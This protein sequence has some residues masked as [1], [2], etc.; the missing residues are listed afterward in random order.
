[1]IFFN[2]IERVIILILFY[3]PIIV[4]TSILLKKFENIF[5]NI[6]KKFFISIDV[7][8]LNMFIIIKIDKKFIHDR[9]FFKFLNILSKF[10][11]DIVVNNIKLIFDENYIN[12]FD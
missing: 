9:D 1:M 12:I 10:Q 5:R 2:T 6:F 7:D 3:K 11:I 8:L 4:K